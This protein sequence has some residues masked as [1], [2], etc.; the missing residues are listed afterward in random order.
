MT[1]Y[2]RLSKRPAAPLVAPIIV[3][4]LLGFSLQVGEAQPNRSSELGYPFVRNFT[5][6]EFKGMEATWA[7]IRDKH[8]IVYVGNQVGVLEFNG[9]DWKTIPTTNKTFVRSFAYDDSTDRIW[10]G[11]TGDF[12]YLDDPQKNKGRRVYISLLE[13]VAEGGDRDFT[14]IWRT[15]QTSDGVYFL[16]HSRLFRYKNDKITVWRPPGKA[17]F[18]FANYINRHLYVSDTTGELLRLNENDQLEAPPGFRRLDD[19]RRLIPLDYGDGK[20]LIADRGPDNKQFHSPLRL[21]NS[22][23][24]RMEPFPNG[25]DKLL[26][27]HKITNAEQLKDD[28]GFAIG[29]TGAGLIILGRDGHLIKRIGQ[30]TGLDD[31]I[32]GIYPDDDGIGLWINN[33]KGLSW[34]DLRPSVSYFGE[35]AHLEGTKLSMVR[36]LGELYVG[37]T[38]GLYKLV[39]KSE[40]PEFETVGMSNKSANSQVSALLST[41]IEGKDRLL[42]GSSSGFFEVVRDYINVQKD[43][44]PFNV[45]CMAVS[46]RDPNRIF[47]GL[48]DGLASVR[49]NGVRWEDEG[50]FNQVKEGNRVQQIVVQADDR[51]WLATEASGVLRVDARKMGPDGT[52]DRNAPVLP[53]SQKGLG[54]LKMFELGG[55]LLFASNNLADLFRLDELTGKFN[56]LDKGDPL[57]SATA[58]S[59]LRGFGF[60]EDQGGNIWSYRGDKLFFLRKSDGSYTPEEKSLPHAADFG[61]LSVVL[62]EKDGVVWFGSLKKLIR[63]DSAHVTP[64]P[65]GFEPVLRRVS[66][67][68]DGKETYDLYGGADRVLAPRESPYN[69]IRFELAI[70][71]LP[72]GSPASNKYKT[73]LEAETFLARLSRESER[74]YTDLTRN[75]REFTDLVPGRYV[76]HVKA[77][78][79]KELEP[80]FTFTIP[81]PRRY[82]WWA[83][84]AYVMLFALALWAAARAQR[85]WER[86]R[87]RIKTE[88]LEAEVRERTIEISRQAETVASLSEVGRQI[89]ASLELDTVLDRVYQY[90]DKIVDAS[91]FG[92]GMFLPA[93]HRLE[94][95]LAIKNGKRTDHYYRDTQDQNQFAVWCLK[96]RQPI[97]MNDVENEYTL[98]LE[99]M[100]EGRVMLERDARPVPPSSVIYLP[101]TTQDRVL[102]VMTIQSVRKNAYTEYQVNLLKSLASYTSIAIDN[103][104][105]YQRLNEREQ[106]IQQQAAELATINEVGKATAS[107][108]EVKSLIELVGEKVR[109]VFKAQIAYVALHDRTE[110]TMNFPYGY[111]R[112]FP[113]VPVSRSNMP[114]RILLGRK[115]LLINK[116][117]PGEYQ[118]A[119]DDGVTSEL[120]VPISAG[121]EIVGVIGVQN[122]DEYRRFTE[123]D[124]RLLVTIAANVGVALHNAR[125]FEETAEARKKAEEADRTKSDFLSTVSHELRTPLTSV[126][127]FAKIIKRRLSEK[128]FPLIPTN[129]S[130]IVLAMQQVTENLDVV[131][132]EGQR[133]TTLINDLLDSATPKNQWRME[134]LAASEIVERAMAATS[135][136]VED[137]PVALKSDIAPDLPRFEGDKNRM[138][139]V[140]INLISNAAKFTKEGSI[141]CRARQQGNDVVISVADTGLGIK[142]EDQGEIFKKFIQVGDTLTDKPKGTGLGLSICKDFVEHLG[143]KIWVESELGQGSTFSLSIPKIDNNTPSKPLSLETLVRRLRESVEGNGPGTGRQSILVVDDDPHIQDLLRQELQDAGHVVR[144]ASDGREALSCVREQKPGL[145]VLDVMM[146]E[147]NGFD[148]AAVLRNDPATMDIPIIMLSIVEDKERGYR[149][150]IDRYLTKPVN[151][152]LLLREIGTLMEQGKS[153]KR[154]MIV[155]EDASTVRTLT[156]VLEVRGYHVVETN[157]NDLVQQAVTLKPDVI[158]LNSVLSAKGEIMQSLRFENGLENVLFLIY[159]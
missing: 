157:G 38:T 14:D 81:T 84:A 106:E 15:I 107:K 146:P 2:P 23:A 69:G 113:P 49:W 57:T 53:F 125:L 97:V 142:K 58:D 17:R 152:E 75:A 80:A 141:T 66:A 45:T 95:R 148:V 18:L 147:M 77:E 78:N 114:S 143:G 50:N 6:S 26:I 59:G 76:F 55:K 111:G 135:S 74:E 39:T 119:M 126:L 151:T 71:F 92:V 93:E 100:E 32:Y 112:E 154:V 133:L 155:D 44:R 124:L 5:P 136:L 123:S 109:E 3:I 158:I 99:K 105:A 96:K 33:S 7:T 1:R 117:S 29:T 56:L 86:A 89:T 149:L 120:G 85:S 137:K 130:K 140:V 132:S 104:T 91:L 82:S 54:G 122:T 40:G 110:G 36:H 88:A 90:V 9:V 102:G 27:D 63:Y 12:G 8:G 42:V 79:G 159:Q 19:S 31:T 48:E 150:G 67:M 144:L 131:V 62:P 16:A 83:L 61:S 138:I 145:V 60:Q 98:Y 22:V 28:D 94:Y 11:S 10:V 4:A 34:V 35:E 30:R 37:T 41:R 103:A 24:E 121:G 64:A 72:D 108:L 129:D 127:G 101:L 65:S 52:P 118:M 128:L 47:V 116:G 21:Y 46:K 25:V 139:Q 43:A 156:E 20:I 68:N 70:P 115:P 73:K 13:K 51:I 153:K 134:P 87:A